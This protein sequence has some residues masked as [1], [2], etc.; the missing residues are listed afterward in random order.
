M[1]SSRPWIVQPYRPITLA[2]A[3]LWT[4]DGDMRLPGGMFPRKMALMRLSDGRIVIHSPIPLNESDM[5]EIERWGKPAFCIVPNRRHRLDASAFRKRYPSLKMLCP[6]AARIRVEKVV[7]VDGGY[8][9]L[10]PELMWQTL[11][12]TDGETAFTFRNGERASLI[13]GDVLF[14]LPH[15]TGALGLIFRIGSTGGPRV[16]PLMKLAV[17][18]DKRRL[19]SQLTELSATPGLERLVPGHGDNIESNAVATL[20]AVANRM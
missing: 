10:P 9:M 17:V 4:V 12:T 7:Q 19:T 6:A 20:R 18:A 2:E 15:L 14:N 8:E 5:A 16:T 1:L 11:A 3:N 13:F